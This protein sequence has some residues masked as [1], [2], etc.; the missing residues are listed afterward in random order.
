[1]YTL[2]PTIPCWGIYPTKIYT[3]IHKKNMYSCVFIHK[4][5]IQGSSIYYSQI[6]LPKAHQ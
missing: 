5:K 2:W 1:M 3:Y 6:E 4:K